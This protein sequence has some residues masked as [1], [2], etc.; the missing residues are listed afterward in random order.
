MKVICRSP[1]V[2]YFYLLTF[3]ILYKKLFYIC[4][5]SDDNSLYSIEDKLKEL[6]L[7]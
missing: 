5:F 7:F 1:F 6:E 3:P 2:Q 4:N